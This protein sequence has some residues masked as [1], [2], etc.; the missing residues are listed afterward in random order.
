MTL[1]TEAITLTG[2]DIFIIVCIAFVVAEVV[3]R[4]L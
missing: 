2:W 4:W 3:K 1:A